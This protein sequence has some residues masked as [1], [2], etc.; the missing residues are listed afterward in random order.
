MNAYS[1]SRLAEDAG[2]SVHI[3]RDYMLRGL[4]HPAR[5]T[6]SGYGFSMSGPWRGCASYVPPLSPVS[7]STN[8]R[9]SVE[10]SMQTI[11]PM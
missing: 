3:V 5:R 2:V 1:I 10:R 11:V 7:G 6:E 4:L 9:G 8:W